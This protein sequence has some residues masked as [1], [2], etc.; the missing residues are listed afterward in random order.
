MKKLVLALAAAA[1]VGAVQAEVVSFK[2]TGTVTY[3]AEGAQVGDVVTGTFGY[4]THLQPVI[5]EMPSFA[6]YDLPPPFVMQAQV[7]A[8]QIHTPSTNVT[9][10][11]NYGG[12][13]EDL[14]TVGGSN[15]VVNGT[16]FTNS[17]SFSITLASSWTNKKALQSFHLPG[18]IDLAKFDAFG[19]PYGTLIIDNITVLQFNVTSVQRQN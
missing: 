19:T 15:P 3:A 7:G 2:F 1:C 13:V 9:I 18:D 17:D 16:Q 6:Y 10:L 11:D 14:I 5:K 12:N 4:D 8:F